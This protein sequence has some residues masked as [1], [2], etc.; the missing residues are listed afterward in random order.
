MTTEEKMYVLLLE[1]IIEDDLSEY[2]TFLQ[3]KNQEYFDKN[4]NS[5]MKLHTLEQDVIKLL[6]SMRSGIITSPMLLELNT[7][8]R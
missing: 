6:K 1:C 2:I 3:E 4:H 5:E 7:M 8:K